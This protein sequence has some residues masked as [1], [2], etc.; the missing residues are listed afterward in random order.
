MIAE[1]GYRKVCA[2]WVPRMLTIKMKAERLRICQ[3][4]LLRYETEGDTF[5]NNIVTGDESWVH[6]YDPENK[7][8][9]ME[10]RHKDSPAPKKFHVQASAG[11]LMFT[12]FWD[13]DGCVLTEFLEK[14]T[15]INSI[16]YI[17]T[18]TALH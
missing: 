15:T 2:R 11:K 6:Y 7:R 18:L 1:L 10:Y 3:Q 12:V 14:G 5:L 4:V 8:Q 17:Q 9:S 13:V 16:R